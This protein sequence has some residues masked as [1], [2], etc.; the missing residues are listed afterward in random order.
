MMHANPLPVIL[1]VALCTMLTRFAPFLA[2]PAGRKRP[3]FILYLSR[4][5][6]PA[7]IGLLV[8]YCFRQVEPGLFPHGLP[9]ALSVIAVALS[10]LWKRNTMLSIGLGTLCYMILIRLMV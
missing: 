6:P 3:A 4:A 9:E 7:V 8:V 1:V 5:L 2:F 10:Y